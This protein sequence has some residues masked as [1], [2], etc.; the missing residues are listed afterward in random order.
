MFKLK[1]F[2]TLFL[3]LFTLMIALPLSASAG[4]DLSP[5]FSAGTVNG[6]VADTA[7]KVKAS[8]AS[9]GFEVIGEYS[10]EG[11]QSFKVII[12]TRSDLKNTA[13]KVADRGLLAAALKVGLT[14]KGGKTS[15]SMVNPEYLFRGYLTKNFDKHEAILKT[16]SEDAKKAVSSVGGTLKPFGGNL[17]AK[18]LKR[19]HY[20]FG[21]EYFSDPV[22]LGKFD[23]F[24]KGLET[25]EKNLASKIA[26]TKKVYSIIDPATKT[27]VFG[28]ALEDPD[29][30][31]QFFL[32]IIGEK[33]L[34]AMPY[35]MILQGDTATMLHGRFRIALHW[36]S[37]TMVTFTKIITTPGAINNTLKQISEN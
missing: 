23:S 31:E 33:H 24:E 18:A 30:G 25:I 36:P 37:L 21:M 3:I 27:A 34:S 11:K 2:S 9:A 35:E 20:M 13:L 10:P 15:V 5:Y 14:E 19:Y 4:S 8:L 6:S 28:I 7:G 1:S 32:P 17:S 16:V 22:K 12:Y 26:G 29:K